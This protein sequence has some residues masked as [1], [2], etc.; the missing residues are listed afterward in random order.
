MATADYPRYGEDDG[1]AVELTDGPLALAAE[2]FPEVWPLEQRE[3]L[4]GLFQDN[5][6]RNLRRRAGSAQVVALESF[7]AIGRAS[8]GSTSGKKFSQVRD[9]PTVTVATETGTG[10]PLQSLRDLCEELVTYS[11]AKSTRRAPPGAEH[12]GA[13]REAAG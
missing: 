4:T 8:S 10:A 1:T 2:D 6:D 13:H 11:G 12:P 9:D 7:R 5:L 3:A